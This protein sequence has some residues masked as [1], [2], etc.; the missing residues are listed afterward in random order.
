ML[1]WDSAFL[2]FSGELLREDFAAPCCVI[3]ER[4][5][6]TIEMRVLLYCKGDIHRVL[7]K[8][9][10]PRQCMNESQT[11]HRRLSSENRRTSANRGKIDSLSSVSIA[12][13]IV[14]KIAFRQRALLGA[15]I[16]CIPL[17][18]LL[19]NE[20]GSKEG[21]LHSVL[22]GLLSVAFSEPKKKKKPYKTFHFA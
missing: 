10:L 12:A 2:F 17:F 11:K 3:K 20:F 1:L 15:W 6:G 19:C 7:S 22:P 13:L 18:C 14:L 5:A 4:V 8:E 9:R 16:L 21:K